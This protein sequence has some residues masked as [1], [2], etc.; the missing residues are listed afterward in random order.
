MQT[1][2]QALFRPFGD[3]LPMTPNHHPAPQALADYLIG[4]CS[5]GTAALLGL[6]FEICPHCRSLIQQ[7]GAAGS[8]T[9]IGPQGPWTSIAPGVEVATA[10][11]ASGIGETVYMLRAVPAA[12]IPLHRPIGMAE[13]LVLAGGFDLGGEPYAAGDFKTVEDQPQMSISTDPNA[14]LRAVITAYQAQDRD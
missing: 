7:M 12:K 14:G 4:D 5:S 6:H 9:A 10:P 3:G 1:V 2:S 11:S 8:P 13:I